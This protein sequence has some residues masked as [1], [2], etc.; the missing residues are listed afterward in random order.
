MY[1][2]TRRKLDHLNRRDGNSS[3]SRYSLRKLVLLSNIF[4]TTRGAEGGREGGRLE[5]ERGR[6]VQRQEEDGRRREGLLD[7]SSDERIGGRAREKTDEDRWLDDVLQEMIDEDE[8]DYVS[9]SFRNQDSETALD[10][11]FLERDTDEVE[12]ERVGKGKERRHHS[13]ERIAE[14]ITVGEE[15]IASSSGSTVQ[16]LPISLIPNPAISRYAISSINT[17]GLYSPSSFSPPLDPPPLEHSPPSFHPA[18]HHSNSIEAS[19]VPYTPP[20][21]LQIQSKADMAS[22]SAEQHDFFSDPRIV[23]PFDPSLPP[24]LPSPESTLSLAL[25]APRKQRP[26]NERWIS[27]IPRSLSVPSSPSSS[28]INRTHPRSGIISSPTSR[29]TSP[30]STLVPHSHSQSHTTTTTTTPMFPTFSTIQSFYDRVDFG[31]DPTAMDFW[32]H[33]SNSARR[34]PAYREE[35]SILEERGRA[36]EV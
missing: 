21:P 36:R 4:G 12:A 3:D 33:Y 22:T 17:T 8:D 11:G 31:I 34:N 24:D 20:L 28:Y 6:E 23:I 1:D 7:G 9:V 2:L 27:T 18:H 32:S 15:S 14:E 26:H 30:T 16:S 19:I 35:E 5:E 25:S 10:S 13:V 29:S